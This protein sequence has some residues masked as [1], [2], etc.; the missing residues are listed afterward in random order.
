MDDLKNA[1]KCQVCALE[2][3]ELYKF[4]SAPIAD[5]R[6]YCYRCKEE[7]KKNKEDCLYITLRIIDL[8]GK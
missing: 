1:K 6:I 4:F 7:E 8:K 2:T 3:T 5:D